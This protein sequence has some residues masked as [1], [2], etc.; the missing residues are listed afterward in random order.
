MSLT[1]G[2]RL[3]P[4]EI[5]AQ[6]G[7]GGM[8]EV[9]RATDRNLGRDVAIKVL[10]EAFAQD[11]ERL[12]RFEREARTLASLNHPNIAIIHGVEAVDGVRAL[13]MELV[14]GDTLADRI[15]RGPVPPAEALSMAR[16]MAAALEA[17]HEQGIIHRDLKPANI[18]VRPDGTV[19]VLDFGLAKMVEGPAA[20]Y[21]ADAAT[22]PKEAG[23]YTMSPTITTP[24][25]FDYRSGRPEHS[26]GPMTQM[27]VILG[28]AAYMSPEQAKGREADKR[29]DLWSF[30]AVVYEMLTGRRAFD[31]DD[32]SETLAT[33]IKSD[34]EWGALPTDVPLPVRTLLRTCLQKDPRKRTVDATTALFVLDHASVLHAQEGEG[35]TTTQRESSL[36]RRARAP[37]AAAVLTAAAI[38]G[39]AWLATRP[40]PLRVVRTTIATTDA[41]FETTGIDSELAITPDGS[42]VV[43]RGAKGLFVR[44]L[45]QLEPK[46]L[47][48]VGPVRNPFASPDGEW[49]GY[50]NANTGTISKVAISGGPPLA[51]TERSVGGAIRGAAWGPDGSIVFG[52]GGPRNGLFR[53]SA[54]GGEPTVITKP[55]QNKGEG[56]HI[57][58]EFLPGGHAVLFTITA[59]RPSDGSQVAVLDMR[60][61]QYK[62]LIRGA[63]HARYVST[64]HLVYAVPGTLRAIPFDLDRLEV[65]GTPVQVLDGVT[66]TGAGAVQ[67]AIATNGTL[68]YLPG[69]GAPSAQ[70]ALVWVDRGGKEEMVAGAPLREYQF[71]RLSPDGTQAALDIRDQ[72]QDIEIWDFAR[73]TMRRL[74]LDPAADQYPVWT[75]DNRIIFASSR[76]AVL[77]GNLYVQAADGTGTAERLVDSPNPQQPQSITADGSGLIIREGRDRNGFDLFL[78]SLGSPRNERPLVSTPAAEVSAELSPNGRWLAYQSGDSGPS[79]VFVRP[80]PDVNAGLFIVSR[81]G[82]RMPLWSRDSREL[83]YVT[84]A[85]VVM[86]VVVEPGDSFRF[87]SPETVLDGRYFLPGGTNSRTFD[88]SRD[89]QRF[90]M[91]KTVAGSASENATNALVVVQNWFEE[92]KRIAPR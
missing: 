68:V 59:S 41:P 70:R 19:K 4:Y 21:A 23:R 86:R 61:S 28:T 44:A 54:D 73:K 88:I 42:R 91:I 43:Y 60:T 17:A 24:A 6:I 51:I 83:F 72:E 89:G 29:S 52:E 13:V 22:A 76:G 5:T 25:P 85:N 48:T 71:P 75:H 34:P 39:A 87:G 2:T 64:G 79:D 57:W 40:A 65:R 45:D 80:F 1:P 55:D 30:G 81:G 77:G 78:L 10:P 14:D 37:I 7:V 12:A 35:G 11:A 90:L 31:G 27:G 67:A 50:V 47:T 69:R 46:G 92:L 16:E 18:K 53:V 20:A 36:W 15:A 26:R 84:P 63:S 8:G 58:P 3:G 49:I 66:T 56:D 9:Y 62:V 38:G 74:T 32:M 82:G 33:V